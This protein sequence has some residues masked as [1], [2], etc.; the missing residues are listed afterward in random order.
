MDERKILGLVRKQVRKFNDE[1]VAQSAVVARR[2]VLW[3]LSKELG[4]T[5]AQADFCASVLLKAWHQRVV[6]LAVADYS[7]L[8]R[9]YYRR[10][11]YTNCM[12]SMVR[13]TGP[14]TLVCHDAAC[15]WCFGRRSERLGELM[16][17]D[18]KA[19]FARLLK[20]HVPVIT[21]KETLVPSKPWDPDGVSYGTD[22]LAQFTPEATDAC[23]RYF[24]GYHTPERRWLAFY[25]AVDVAPWYACGGRMGWSILTRTLGLRRGDVVHGSSAAAADRS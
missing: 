17:L 20:H 11:L 23:A 19:R 3:P 6:D 14:K 18:D 5:H 15:P 21:R 13:Y 10:L 12:P 8:L 25:R 24:Y 22:V 1:P 2:A 4:T 7:P 9:H 16:G